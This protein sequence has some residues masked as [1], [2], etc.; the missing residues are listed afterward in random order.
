MCQKDGNKQQT[1]STSSSSSLSLGSSGSGSS[2][3]SSRS[4][5]SSS[6]LGFNRLI[7]FFGSFLSGSSGR[8]FTTLQLLQNFIALFFTTK[9]SPVFIN[10]LM[11]IFTKKYYTDFNYFFPCAWGAKRV[12]LTTGVLIKYLHCTNRFPSVFTCII[13]FPFNQVFQFGFFLEN[14]DMLLS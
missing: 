4:R 9:S 13:I 10:Q 14:N 2:S 1:F 8:S 11:G 5:T 12:A 6:L 7:F 3:G